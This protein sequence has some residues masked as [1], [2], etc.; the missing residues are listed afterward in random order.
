VDDLSCRLFL[1]IIQLKKAVFGNFR[2]Q[3][4]RYRLIFC[5]PFSM[6][7]EAEISMGFVAATSP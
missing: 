2:M 5:L 1:L 3:L 7:Q 4:V 6:V